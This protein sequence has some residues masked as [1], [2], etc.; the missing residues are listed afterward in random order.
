M[1]AQLFRR[2][3]AFMIHDAF[4]CAVYVS[5]FVKSR[6]V[7]ES[8]S[9]ALSSTIN[10]NINIFAPHYVVLAAAYASPRPQTTPGRTL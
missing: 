4:M 2:R 7:S 10:I 8:A 3:L 9:C 1:S 5:A 6:V